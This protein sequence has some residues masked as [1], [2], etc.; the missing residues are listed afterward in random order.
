MWA[1]MHERLRRGS[2]KWGWEM[3]CGAG[4]IL[5]LFLIVIRTVNAETSPLQWAIQPERVGTAAD[6]DW[7][8]GFGNGRLVAVSTEGKYLW[9]G[10]G[11]WNMESSFGDFDVAF[12]NGRFV[13]L[14]SD[15][16]PLASYSTDGAFW[17]SSVDYVP[18]PSLAMAY[19]RGRFVTGGGGYF[20]TS[21]LGNEWEKLACDFSETLY[22]LVFG[23]GRFVALAQLNSL[24]TSVNLTD[25]PPTYV[26]G[27]GVTHFIRSVAFGDGL[28]I[29][30]GED[31]GAPDREVVLTSVNGMTWRRQVYPHNEAPRR[32]LCYGNGLFAGGGADGTLYASSDGRNWA[33]TKLDTS[34]EFEDVVFA[35]GRFAAVARDG[36]FALSQ[37][38]A[39][40]F[41]E[42]Q[43]R[44]KDCSRLPDGAMLL[45]VEGPYGQAVAVEASED[46]VNWERI[47]TDPCDR[48]EFEVYDEAAAVL[49]HRF[50]RAVE[51]GPPPPDPLKTWTQVDATLEEGE[52][53]DWRL[54]YGNDRFVAAGSTTESSGAAW[55]S[56]DGLTWQRSSSA[57]AHENLVFGAGRF[58][59]WGGATPM[60]TVNG[61]DWV[62]HD[63]VEE[64][65][66]VSGMAFGRN[67][68]VGL[69]HPVDEHGFWHMTYLSSADGEHWLQ[70]AV[71]GT[72]AE[73]GRVSMVY[74]KG[75]TVYQDY[76]KIMTYADARWDYGIDYFGGGLSSP[77]LFCVSYGKGRFVATGSAWYYTSED[78]LTW[79][80][81]EGVYL[82]RITYAN[83]IFLACSI[84]GARLYRSPDGMIW[85]ILAELQT[86]AP[87]SDLLF[88]EGRFYL[89]TRGGEMWRSEVMPPHVTEPRVIPEL[90]YRLPDGAM[91]ITVEAPY[92][93]EVVVEGSEDLETWQEIGRDPCDRGEFEIYHESAPPGTDW[94]YRARQVEP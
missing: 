65:L 46:M 52:T 25:W 44:P 45:T 86:S 51:W 9:D 5:L 71:P 28:F 70:E 43:F 89:V 75:R 3:R 6:A 19:G 35:D 37:K 79:T 38:M 23:K 56:K 31:G 26:E 83:G 33:V 63:V 62:Q 53:L 93:H 14:R 48:G 91:L 87:P 29:A 10:G 67:R 78:G 57:A 17:G 64:G 74:G 55:F 77:S 4:V 84:S 2:C 15:L 22:A 82:N 8:L 73:A 47:A 32:G 90:T 72:H 1:R 13:G 88:A 30:A 7:R 80:S 39:P 76:L 66:E 27:P 12:G 68:F 42:I 58:A 94:F 50:Y 81:H 11:A 69:A 92:G 16:P 36:T 61:Q 60:S 59:T 18:Y 54:A 20:A 41:E 34:S 24:R 49:P 21:Q 40:S 85:T